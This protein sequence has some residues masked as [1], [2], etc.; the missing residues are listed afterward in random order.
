MLAVVFG[1][2]GCAQLAT[3]KQTHAQLPP[4]TATNKQL[5]AAKQCLVSGERDEPLRS[6]GKDLAATKLSLQVLEQQPNDAAAHNLYNFAVSRAVQDVQA[7]NLQPWRRQVSV[8]AN[9]SNYILTSPKPAD[10][11][12][13]ASRYDLLPTDTLKIGGSF[14]QN[15][16][17]VRGI[18]APIVAV[19]RNENPDFRRQYKY[20]RVY[21][22]V[23][24]VIRFSGRN[25]QLEF[26][27][28][29]NTERV[30]LNQQTFPLAAD[31]DAPTAVLIARDRPE[32]LGRAR[33]LNPELYAD[34]SMLCQLQP[35]DSKRTPVIFIHGLQ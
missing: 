17:P 4:V 11:D 7:A 9:P 3:V 30:T 22:P 28:P 5:Q 13:D 15:Y 6:L 33:V 24:A 21:A 10:S 34:T 35:F 20:H 27:D 26:I 14:F 23:T 12:H 29:L 32:R 2:C 31:F 16:S 19:G 8:P 18:G 1:G 25:A